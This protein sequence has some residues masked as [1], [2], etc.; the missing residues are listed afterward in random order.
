[1]TFPTPTPVARNPGG[2]APPPPLTLLIGEVL[3]TFDAYRRVKK[4][5]RR[6]TRNACARMP[7]SQ[8]IPA[9]AFA[10]AIR[11]EEDRKLG[12]AESSDT[13]EANSYLK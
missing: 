10:R 12:V 2:Q 6:P 11:P 7:P 1:M 3:S 4:E 9:L 5:K 13:E 8:S